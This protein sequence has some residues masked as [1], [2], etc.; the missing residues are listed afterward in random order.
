MY[1]L[2]LALC[3][4]VCIWLEILVYGCWVNPEPTIGAMGES[5][6]LP[7]ERHMSLGRF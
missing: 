3:E 5:E 7:F 6:K 1:T 2:F 4:H